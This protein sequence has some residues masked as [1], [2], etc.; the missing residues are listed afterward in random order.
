M[1]MHAHPSR[2]PIQFL[3]C[4]CPA[5]AKSCSIGR[6]AGLSPGRANPASFGLFARVRVFGLSGVALPRLLQRKVDFANVIVTGFLATV[7]TLSRCGFGG[8]LSRR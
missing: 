4:T 3:V 8:R 7:S 2:I 6:C 5:S 1:S